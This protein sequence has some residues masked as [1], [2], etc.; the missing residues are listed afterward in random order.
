MAI[1]KIFPSKDASLYTISQS[2]NTG[3]DEI[4]EAST[5]IESSQPQV[6]RY[7][8]EFSQTEINNFVEKH[9][10]GSGVTRLIIN[11][12][13]VG[14]GGEFLYDQD[15]SAGPTY[16]TSS[17]SISGQTLA[18]NNNL[19]FSIVP[20]SSFG[21]G[22]GQ[23]F[24]VGLNSGYFIPGVDIVDDAVV[25]GSIPTGFAAADGTYGPFILSHVDGNLDLNRTTSSLSS[26]VNL[27]IENN[28]LVSAVI[29]NNGSA[30]YVAAEYYPVA[31]GPLNDGGM[32]DLYISEATMD[33]AYPGVFTFS[34]PTDYRH[35]Y[36][37]INK[38]HTVTVPSFIRTLDSQ[39]FKYKAGDKLVFPSQSFDPYP[40]SDD[41]SITLSAPTVSGSNWEDVPAQYE[42]LNSAAVVTGVQMDQTLKV[43]AVSGSW[44]MGTGKYANNPVTTNGCSW[45]FRNYSGSA[46]D[47]ATTWQT[48]GTFGNYATK[49]MMTPKQFISLCYQPLREDRNQEK[50]IKYRESFEKGIPLHT[51]VL[52]VKKHEHGWE[53]I[54]HEGRHRVQSLIDMGY[55]D[56]KIP[57]SMW[58]SGYM[59]DPYSTKG[60]NDQVNEAFKDV[61][62]FPES[63]GEGNDLV[64]VYGEDVESSYKTGKIVNL[65]TEERKCKSCEKPATNV[66]QEGSF[67][68]DCLPIN[69]GAENESKFPAFQ[70]V[71]SVLLVSLLP[72][73]LDNRRDK[74]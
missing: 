17:N 52:Q 46:G 43:Y 29:Q 13:G 23:R 27:T 71:G 39:G 11:D 45:I 20:S 60:N 61:M 8:L 47:G 4:L 19:E 33:A 51:P 72:L 5:A 18:V 30:S 3:L 69:L 53:V 40:M 55:G 31:R 64:F 24:L 15:M 58:P 57:V 68:Y 42:L 25:S 36:F 63:K 1:Y 7:L 12:T 67:C 38:I 9:I 50:L 21:D 37:N 49:V 26:S 28:T 35:F 6:S 74:V 66:V 41:V 32:G 59:G 34:G 2:M 48:T 16:P 62:I 70:F 22:Y 14:T 65:A 44:N 56:V 54:G 10:S 73:F